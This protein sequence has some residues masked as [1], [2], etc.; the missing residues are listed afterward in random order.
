M[1]YQITYL[2]IG[3]FIAYLFSRYTFRQLS[4]CSFEDCIVVGISFIVGLFLWPA[5][6]GFVLIG[7]IIWVI[8]EYS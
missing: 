3:L 2:I 8:K 6:L 1:A 5:I 4:P 7:G